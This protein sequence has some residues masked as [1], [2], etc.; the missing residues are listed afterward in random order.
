MALLTPFFIQWTVDHVLV[1]SDDGLLTVLTIGFLLVLVVQVGASVARAYSMLTIS[2]QLG[3][4]WLGRIAGHLTKLPMDFFMRR[5]MGEIMS[6]IGSLGA[7][8]RTLTGSFIEGLL[9]GLFVITF[10]GIMATYSFQLASISLLATILYASVRLLSFQHFRSRAEKQ[11]NAS[12][13]LQTN[14]METIRGVHTLKTV[15]AEDYR[16]AG[17]RALISKSINAEIRVGSLGVAVGAIN[18]TLLGANGRLIN[19]YKSDESFER[20]SVLCDGLRDIYSHI[21]KHLL[22]IGFPRDAM[23]K[24]LEMRALQAEAYTELMEENA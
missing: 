11:L 3:S 4:Q 6:R 24:R 16:N 2:S 20:K 1:S 10:L 7:I 17:T 21:A 15:G 23:V 9:D 8:Q 22:E 5:Q 18:Q 19:R 13:R 14:L 12:A